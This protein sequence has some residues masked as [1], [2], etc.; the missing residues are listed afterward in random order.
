M[1]LKPSIGRTVIYRDYDFKLHPAVITS[2]ADPEEEK[3]NLFVMLDGGGVRWVK[4][5]EHREL[6]VKQSWFW[7]I[8]V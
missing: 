1:A 7:P 8:R 2:V 5:V 3:V 6:Q 4:D